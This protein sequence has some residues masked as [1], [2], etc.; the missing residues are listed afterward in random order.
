MD[1][2]VTRQRALN[3]ALTAVAVGALTGT[4]VAAP[5]EQAPA[6][7]A[8]GEAPPPHAAQPQAP[9]AHAPA[10]GRRGTQPRSATA[11]PA[12][13]AHAPA[14]GRRGTRP[15]QAQRK[16][17]APGTKPARAP[18]SGEGRSKHRGGKP[19]GRSGDHGSNRRPKLTLCHATGSATNPYV[20]IT[21]ADRAVEHAHEGHQHDED[22]IPAP[23]GGC[24]TPQEAAVEAAAGALRSALGARRG[25]AGAE[26][27]GEREVLTS[28][29]VGVT[30][31]PGEGRGVQ[32][33][34]RGDLQVLGAIETEDAQEGGA[35]EATPTAV[36]S[37]P[38]EDGELPFTGLELAFVAIAGLAA[39]LAGV[40]LRR[41]LGQHQ[42]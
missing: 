23:A 5:P 42:R 2:K 9:R 16:A 3:A 28:S 27:S 14:H 20:T 26:E 25:A 32:G 24:P 40:A 39:L 21:I 8:R 10:H 41:A 33:E 12:P 7:G 22:L 31:A 18:E 37:Q 30:P 6:H 35:S 29:Q 34:E 13:P 17:A 19:A 11:K 1:R 38:S 36:A 15:A 4:A